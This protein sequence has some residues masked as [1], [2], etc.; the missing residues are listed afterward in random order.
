MSF[1]VL[2]EDGRGGR[3][4]EDGRSLVERAQEVEEEERDDWTMECVSEGT[5]LYTCVQERERERRRSTKG[6]NDRKEGKLSS[7]TFSLRFSPS[8]S[9]SSTE[10]LKAL[11]RRC[12]AE[13]EEGEEIVSG[14]SS[15]N[16]YEIEEGKPEVE[17]KGPS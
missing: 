4:K 16:P 12:E 5:G 8:S 1:A 2:Q 15:F 9:F 13:L 17:R 14:S 6:W 7:S 11:V 3:R 10:P